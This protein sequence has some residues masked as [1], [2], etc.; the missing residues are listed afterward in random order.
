MRSLGENLKPWPCR[1][2]LAIF[3][4]INLWTQTYVRLLLVSAENNVCE[5]EPGNNFCDVGILSQS[6]FSSSSPS[7]VFAARSTRVSSYHGIWLAKEKQKSL[8]HRNCFLARVRRCYF[9]HRQATAGNTFVFAGHWSIRQ[10]L[11]LR[12]SHK[13][14][15]VGTH[16]ETSPY[17]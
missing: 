10:G 6:Q 14:L 13:D 16:E 17:D 9:R 15:K 4:S 11:G 8:R 12:F 7:E 3:R 2:V 1:I 5:P